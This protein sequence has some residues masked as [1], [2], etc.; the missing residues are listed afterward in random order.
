MAVSAELWDQKLF[1]GFISIIRLETLMYELFATLCWTMLLEKG[2]E[3]IDGNVHF[4]G[5]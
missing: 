2:L 1:I 3:T 4:V 5:R